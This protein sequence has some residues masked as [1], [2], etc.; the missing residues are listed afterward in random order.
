MNKKEFLLSVL[1]HQPKA[2]ERA[3]APQL[4]TAKKPSTPSSKR[5]EKPPPKEADEFLLQK[6][7]DATLIPLE[8][9]QNQEQQKQTWYTLQ[10]LEEERN[11][12]RDSGD[13]DR[14]QWFE[15]RLRMNRRKGQGVKI[16]MPEPPP[17]H[18]IYPKELLN[19]LPSEIQTAMKRNMPAE[20]WAKLR[21]VWALVEK[22]DSDARRGFAK[23]L[24]S[25]VRQRM[26]E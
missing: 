1:K 18:S 16:L 7:R 5:Q 12:A 9:L 10:E 8:R 14:E 13:R 20:E 21:E 3:R 17:D 24:E 19:L 6:L 25:Q 4:P 11:R 2:A 15:E 22:F 23:E 26:E